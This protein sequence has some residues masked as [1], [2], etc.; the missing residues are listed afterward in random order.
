MRAEI[1][2]LEHET[3]Q[4]EH[5]VA[6]L[7]ALDDVPGLLRAFDQVVHERVDAVGAALSE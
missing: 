5:C 6:D 2:A 1:D 3:A 7:P 4:G